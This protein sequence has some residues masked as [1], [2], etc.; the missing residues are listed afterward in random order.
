MRRR[1]FGPKREEVAGSLRRLY[2]EK[3]HNLCTSPNIIQVIKS[4]RMRW[5][6]PVALMGEMGNA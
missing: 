3:L 5:V 4:K 1:M 2:N 6:V